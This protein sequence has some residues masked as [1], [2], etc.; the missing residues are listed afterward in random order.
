MPSLTLSDTF[1]SIPKGGVR[2]ILKDMGAPDQYGNPAPNYTGCIVVKDLMTNKEGKIFLRS[3]RVYSTALSGFVPP[4]STRM[5][6]AGLINKEIFNYLNTIPTEQ[7]KEE[8]LK[9]GYCTE[10]QLEDINRQMLMSTITH[11][12][13]WDN[14]EWKWVENLDTNIYTISPLEIR[15]LVT[16]ADERLGQW[17]ALSR[18]FLSTT[19]GN[20]V[21][22][23]GE[24]W[25]SKTGEVTTPEIASILKFVDGKTTISQIAKDCG[26]TR[27]EIA[28]RLAKAIADGILIIPDPDGEPQIDLDHDKMDISPEINPLEYELYQA[29]SALEDL[30]KELSAAEDR[31]VQAQQAL[32]KSK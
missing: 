21:P 15:L 28:A 18:N 8:I 29:L 13:G 11:L 9:H 5:L 16:A 12:Y 24:A 27:F 22:L 6:S 7:I 32:K 17:N 2:T 1:T 26:F 31:V 10:D 25:I 19:K 30:K 4:I 20:S 23:P 3:G 14:A